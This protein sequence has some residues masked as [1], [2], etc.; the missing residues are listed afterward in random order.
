MIIEMPMQRSKIQIIVLLFLISMYTTAQEGILDPNFGYQGTRK[1]EC[2]DKDSRAIEMLLLDDNSMILA[3]NSEIRVNGAVQNRGFYIFK[4]SGDGT[5]I[6][7]FGINGSLYFPNNNN[8]RSSIST[9]LLQPDGKIVIKAVIEAES[10]LMRIFQDGTFDNSF[11]NG[12]IQDIE[13]GYAIGLQ[14]TGKIIVQSQYFDGYNNMYS[15]S[16]RNTDGSLDT[17]FGVNGTQVTDVTTYRFDLCFTI[18]IDALDRILAAG[19]SYNNGDDYHPVITRFNE[20]GS[21]DTSF[22]NNGTLITT[23][24]PNSNLGEV[25]DIALFNESILLG[26]NYQYQGGTGGFGGI[27]PAVAK[28][29]NDGTMDHSFG[30]QGRVIMNTYYNA[31]DRLR[32]IAVQRDGKILLG[33]G[34]SFPYPYSQT[35][36]FV[37]KLNED[38]SIYSP[39]GQNGIFII[40]FNGS[41][42]NYVTDVALL[43]DNKVMVFGNTTDE[44]HEFRNAIICR[45]ENEYL[46]TEEF[47]IETKVVVFPNPTTEILQIQSSSLISRIELYNVLGQLLDSQTFDNFQENIEYNMQRFSNGIYIVLIHSDN[48]SITSKKVLKQ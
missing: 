38:G 37:S 20:N 13:G 45:L 14:S 1:F 15:F 29:N 19:A 7:D 42:F 18:K 22:A 25:N 39:F 5:I 46:N 33:G 28:L 17:T 32:S 44:N 9:M 41:D 8:E 12:G 40:R 30:R 43:P 48:K 34:A 35:D 21:L 2:V 24:G 23:F 3:V 6:N 10:K 47:L 4:I 36:F 26:G 11:G 16:R 31:N 27:K